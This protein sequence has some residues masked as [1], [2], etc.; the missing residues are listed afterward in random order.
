M[1]KPVIFW[2][3]QDLRLHDLPGLAA[4]IDT[5][6][7]LLVCYILDEG[8]PG[9]W[10][11][12]GASRWWLHHSLASLAA[13]IEGLGGRLLL[14]RG[15]TLD[16]LHDL[17]DETDADTVYCSRQ[18]EPWARRLERSA[19]RALA[20]RAVAVKRYPGTLLWEP[21]SIATQSGT[22]FK[23]F[24]PFWRTCRRVPPPAAPRKWRKSPNWFGPPPQ[25]DALQDWHLLPTH[26]DW[27]AAWPRLWQPGAQPA[28]AR[29]SAFLRGGIADYC[30]GRDF[31][32]RQATSGLSTHLHFGELSPAQV[33]HSAQQ[34]AAGDPALAEPV[35]KFLSELA[36]REFSYHLLWHFPDIPDAPFKTQFA[37]FPWQG[38]EQGLRAWQRGET[39]YPLVDAGMRELWQTGCMHNRVRM[40]V[41]SFLTKHLLIHWRAGAKWFW[42]T[43][44][45][46]DLA[47]N[48]CSWQWVAG[49]GADASPYFRIFNPTAQSEKFDPQ[50]SYVRRWVPELAKLP[51]QYLHRPWR[52]P[53]DVLADAAVVLGETYP[54]PIVD[55]RAAR[56]SAL[57]AYAQVKSA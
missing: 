41:A 24:T 31:P 16:T 48:S 33:W 52:A 4:A 3:R 44:L 54:E 32:A 28:R 57:A 1:E 34:A 12:G 42:D 36:W 25:G 23:V 55:H 20:Q 6:R 15:D 27:A 29:L 19:Q 46:A 30:Q 37:Q 10:A 49:S 2:F 17:V 56:E 14:R 45:D 50:G 43:L 8:A 13:D 38:T 51:D 35:E 53:A 7:P 39:G 47:N 26:P 11:P 21:E 9:E 40:V 18:Y 5:G 22:P